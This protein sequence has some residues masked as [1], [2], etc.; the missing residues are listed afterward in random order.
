MKRFIIAL[1]AAVLGLASCE[2]EPAKAIIGTWEATTMEMTM[3]GVNMT[4]DIADAGVGMEFTFRDN[5]TG[6]FSET[7][8]G[9]S[10]SMDFNYSVDDN[11]LI[12]EVEGDTAEIPV[13]IEKKNMTM[14]MDGEML[15]EPGISIKVHFVKK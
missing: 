9:E 15:D 2:K 6:T 8:E 14:I 11:T 10:V 13:T 7:S 4:I 1:T 12:M 3:E 5:G